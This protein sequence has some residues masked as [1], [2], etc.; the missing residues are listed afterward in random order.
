MKRK[1]REKKKDVGWQNER[2]KR[3][4][5]RENKSFRVSFWNEWWRLK[6]EWMARIGSPKIINGL[7]TLAQ[8]KTKQ[9]DLKTITQ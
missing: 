9:I 7:E 2:K 6:D 4:D 5:E 8:K 1:E 3:E